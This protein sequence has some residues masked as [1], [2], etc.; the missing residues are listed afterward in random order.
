MIWGYLDM[1]LSPKLFSDS[2]LFLFKKEENKDN[3]RYNGGDIS[4]VL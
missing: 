3:E 2:A 4:V 1:E